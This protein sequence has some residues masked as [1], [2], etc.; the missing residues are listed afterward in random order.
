MRAD[1][2]QLWQHWQQMHYPRRGLPPDEATRADLISLDGTSGTALDRYFRRGA[3]GKAFDPEARGSL[4]H[5]HR[6]LDR[7]CSGLH[8][9]AER[10]FGRL[11]RLIELILIEANGVAIG[12]GQSSTPSRPSRQR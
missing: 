11:R 9:D 8:A 12:G 2:Y 6:E 7:L 1:A 4:D 5:C 3:G 10:Y